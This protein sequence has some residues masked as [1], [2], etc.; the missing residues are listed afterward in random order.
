ME[1]KGV[2]SGEANIFPGPD[3]DDVYSGKGHQGQLVAVNGNPVP[4]ITPNA[5]IAGSFNQN[6]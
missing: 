5:K 1:I 2:A 6:L 3:E 4:R